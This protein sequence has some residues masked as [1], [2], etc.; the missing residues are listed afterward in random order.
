MEAEPSNADSPDAAGRSDTV[1]ERT[2]AR[3]FRLMIRFLLA[4]IAFV[5][6][7][8]VFWR[9][10]LPDR[11]FAI[12]P[13]ILLA[14]LLLLVRR[15][16]IEGVLFVGSLSV[17]GV[18]ASTLFFPSMGHSEDRTSHTILTAALGALIGG[19]VGIIYR[20]WRHG[21]LRPES[22]GE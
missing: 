2:A 19:V 16:Q 9:Y 6:A 17:I 14:T 11:L 22:R 7:F 20:E 10:P 21:S 4:A 15:N 13:G 5:I 12:I 1:S 18:L 8:A 3:L